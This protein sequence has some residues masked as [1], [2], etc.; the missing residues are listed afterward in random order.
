LYLY[1]KNL[2]EFAIDDFNS[3]YAQTGK[4]VSDP[5]DQFCRCLSVS[6]SPPLIAPPAFT[7]I[8]A[9]TL[10]NNHKKRLALNA[11]LSPSKNG[12]F[13]FASPPISLEA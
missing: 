2:V 7:N 5:A 1:L 3:A 12:Y 4:T 13:P 6:I 11:H 8:K 10:A 9:S